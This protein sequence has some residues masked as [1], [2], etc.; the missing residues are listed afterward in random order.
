MH[1]D[2]V[3][4]LSTLAI[5]D[6]AV[7]G[8]SPHV[9]VSWWK[10]VLIIIPIVGWAWM[11]SSVF[12]KHA[13]RFFLGPEKWNAIHLGF[14]LA[15]LAAVVLMPLPG[16][17]GFLVGYLVL[18]VMLA[19]DILVFVS[20]TNKDERVPEQHHLRLDFS[21][22]KEARLARSEAKQQATV[23][24]E[25]KGPSGVVIRAPQKDSPEYAIR[26][27]AEQIF[28]KARQARASQVD[29]APA[30]ESTY[31]ASYLIDGVRQ[32]GDPIPAPDAMK[33]I[34]FW[35][36]C[37]ELDLKDRRRKL[38]NKIQVHSGAENATV[39]IV[40]SGS[41]SGMRLTMVFNPAESVRRDI[42]ELGLL[43]AQLES[44]RAIGK[45]EGGI[46]LVASPSD[47]GRTTTM[48][49]LLR[50][51]DAYTENVQTI[52][53]EIEDRLEGARQLQ[54]EPKEDGPDYATT[55]R[56]VLRR[57]PDV[58]G[59]MEL[60]DVETAKEIAKADL[61]RSRVYVSV[62]A[63]GALAAAQLW[64]KAVGDSKAASKDLTGV[65]A[66]KL[67]RKLCENCR[68][69]YQPPA[70]ILKK[71]GLPADR[72]KQLH[73]KGG[74]VLIR[75]KPEVC[76]ACQGLG[77]IGQLG[78]FEVYELDDEMRA[79]LAKQDWSGLRN[80]LRKTQRPTIQQAAL[81]RAVEGLT[82]IEEVMRVTA[83]PASPSPSKKKVARAAPAQPAAD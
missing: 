35:K 28:I 2:P 6:P 22:F 59:V 13:A 1:S 4:A 46:V 49:S 45:K 77:Y 50:L 80:A 31:A 29:F 7:L 39:K 27:A 70:E 71:L 9:L 52:E 73:K 37:A 18:L 19:A 51:H 56:S 76:P 32:A 53:L 16:I 12:D 62:K 21:S 48:Y 78:V 68:V 55:V 64:V 57:D 11:V 33:L 60:P 3:T 72:V 74:Q 26:A 17:A 63:E 79:A 24:L 34:D 65:V 20:V 36:G 40:T 42:D 15:G 67:V 25:I 83:A 5:I 38:S 43:D 44:V 61:A 54:Y 41:Q 47:H 10:A 69:P 81:R 14:G 8:E 82:S 66:Q 30:G 23:E 75:N 58:V